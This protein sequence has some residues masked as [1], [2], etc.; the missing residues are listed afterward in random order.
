MRNQGSRRPWSQ[1]QPILS[2]WMVCVV[3]KDVDVCVS[4]DL[5][6]DGTLCGRLSSDCHFHDHSVVLI[7]LHTR[8]LSGVQRWNKVSGKH[9]MKPEEVCT[10]QT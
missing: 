5:I 7:I 8:Q 9:Q 6:Q 1:K 4:S 3:N 2:V 10:G